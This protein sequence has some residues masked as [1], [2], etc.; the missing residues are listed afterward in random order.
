MNEENRHNDEV[1][2]AELRGFKEL[3][4]EYKDV[5][6]KTL[7]RIELQTTATNGRVTK[8]ELRAAEATG[9]ARISNIIWSAMVSIVVAVTAV[10]INKN[11]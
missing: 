7:T 10:F 11:I 1:I 8:L 3:F 2:M 5:N 9:G 6:E 4:M